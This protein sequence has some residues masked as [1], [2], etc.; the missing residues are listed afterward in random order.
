MN[1]AQYRKNITEQL[2]T[3]SD[4]PKLDAELL[5]MHATQKTR[6]QLLVH[7]DEELSQ[8]AEKNL[9]ALVAR[10]IKG[11]PIAYIL[12]HQPFWSMD[13]FVTSD[14]LIPRPDTECLVEWILAHFA[15]ASQLSIADLG[16]GTG[17]IAI[18][19]ALEKPQWQID[20]TDFS[21]EALAVAKKNI[22][23]YAVNTIALHQGDWCDALP[24]KKYD[25]I[26]SNP[27]YIAEKDSHLSSLKFE[28]QQAL[29]SGAQGLNA[30]EKITQQATLFLKEK[31][32]LIVEHGYDQGHLVAELFKKAGFH[33][34]KNHR[35]LSDNL[36]FVTGIL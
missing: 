18:A 19:L 24:Q 33:S 32:V 4:S 1:I 22:E 23:K 31:G 9:T 17:A 36:R 25:V 34:I 12:G 10:R 3:H 27:P 6:S 2:A 11:E 7:Y 13:L 30:I 21:Y 29:V 26:V 20:A 8:S 14:T 16:T 35:D 28:P 5:I 15:T